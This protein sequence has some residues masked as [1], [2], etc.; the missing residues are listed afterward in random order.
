M[1]DRSFLTVLG[2]SSE[3]LLIRG[4]QIRELIDP[5]LRH[6]MDRDKRAI[7]HTGNSPSCPTACYPSVSTLG[8]EF[9]VVY[10]F[11]AL[12]R[13]INQRQLLQTT[14]SRQSAPF[15]KIGVNTTPCSLFVNSPPPYHSPPP[16]PTP[17][18]QDTPT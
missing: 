13:H 17:S 6:H 3:I 12:T 4:G 9:P 2:S 15:Q 14:S 5:P 16:H 1:T 7:L 18:D 11:C 8:V 10:P